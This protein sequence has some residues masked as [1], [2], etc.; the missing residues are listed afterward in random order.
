MKIENEPIAVT[1]Y[2]HSNYVTDILIYWEDAI[3]RM[4]RKV[5]IPA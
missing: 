1:E 2:E 5:R 4:I 3:S